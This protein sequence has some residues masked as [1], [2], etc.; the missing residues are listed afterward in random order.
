MDVFNGSPQL[1]NNLITSELVVRSN[2]G[3]LFA[4]SMEW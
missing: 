3:M 2:M 1:V 4:E